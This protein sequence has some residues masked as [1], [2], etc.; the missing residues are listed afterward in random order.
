M[1]NIKNLYKKIE[2]TGN[3]R[4]IFF[5]KQVA[6]KALEHLIAIELVLPTEASGKC[7][8]EYRMM[9]VLLE[10]NQITQAVLKHSE[11]PTS[12]KQWGTRWL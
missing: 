1:T 3:G 5:K 7:P 10:P 11:C 2:A 8:K 6:M 9:K 12:I 4:E